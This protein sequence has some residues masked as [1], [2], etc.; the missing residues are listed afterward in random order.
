[1]HIDIKRRQSYTE[2][3]KRNCMQD[4]KAS[5]KSKSSFVYDAILDAILQGDL[6]AGEKLSET[7]LAETLNVSRTPVREALRTL[8][9]EGF[10]RLSPGSRFEITSFS[11]KDAVEVLQI[12][13]LLEGEASRQAALKRCPE[14]CESLQENLILVEECIKRA[15]SDMN[16]RFMQLDIAFHQAIFE[17]AGN[18]RMQR[19]SAA[20]GDRQARYYISRSSNAEMYRICLQQHRNIAEA[21]SSHDDLHAEIYARRH[22]EFIMENMLQTDGKD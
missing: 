15:D 20:L 7:G 13:R 18:I 11:R 8:D 10:V 3:E 16:Y 17:M 21:I 5:Y 1:M 14:S 4:I 12:R 9:A 6:K 2:Q 19:V 22:I